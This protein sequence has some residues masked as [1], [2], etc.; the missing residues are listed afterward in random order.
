MRRSL[1]CFVLLFA[2]QVP[3]FAKMTKVVVGRNPDFVAVNAVTNTI[4]ASDAGAGTVSVIDGAS[5]KTTATI[6]VGGMPQ[7]IAVNPAT[8]MIYVALFAGLSSTVSVIDG[9]DNSIVAS[10]PVPGATYVVADSFTNRIYTSDSDNTVR[11][12]DGS[13]N[14]VVATISFS[15]VLEGIA[16]D[17]TRNLV[18]VEEVA[19]PPSVGVIDGSTNTVTNTIS[20]PQAGFLTGLAVDSSLNQIYASDSLVMKL[21]VISGATGSVLSSVSLPGAGNPKYA[22]LGL[23]GEVMVTDPSTD[24]IFLVNGTTR[25]LDQTLHVLFEPWGAATNPITGRMYVGLSQAVYVDVLRP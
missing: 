2:Y 9:S 12:I 14:T 16:V 11:V 18:Y 5:N 8:N 21:F 24:H 25:K 17:V 20:V 7:G 19:T 6:T 4:Y 13:S 23:N 22:A 10:I 1:F 15:S 3:V